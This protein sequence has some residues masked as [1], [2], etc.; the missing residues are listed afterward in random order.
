MAVKALVVWLS[1]PVQAMPRAWATPP[2]KLQEASAVLLVAAMMKTW[3]LTQGEII[4]TGQRA[5]P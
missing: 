2:V 3:L 5:E 1:L 4:A